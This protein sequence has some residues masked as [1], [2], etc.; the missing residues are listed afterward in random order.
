MI[1]GVA[2]IIL[3]RGVRLLPRRQAPVQLLTALLPI[4]L[5]PATL[6]FALLLMVLLLALLLLLAKVSVLGQGLLG[7]RLPLRHIRREGGLMEGSAL[8]AT[9]GAFLQRVGGGVCLGSALPLLLPD[10]NLRSSGLS[11]GLL[12]SCPPLVERGSG[13]V[14][15]ALLWSCPRPGLGGGEGGVADVPQVLGRVHAQ[16][17]P[18]RM[19]ATHS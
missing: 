1:W 6:L 4:T 15:R 2:L 7:G 11:R 17:E 8:R 13:L 9:R 12:C 19:W 18:L 14:I 16:F 3:L 5:L 10:L